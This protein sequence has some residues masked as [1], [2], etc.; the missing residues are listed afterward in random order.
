MCRSWENKRV[1]GTRDN[2]MFLSVSLSTIQVKH[3]SE[4]DFSFS[5][6]VLNTAPQKSASKNL[7]QEPQLEKDYAPGQY[8]A[9]DSHWWLGNIIHVIR[10]SSEFS[11]AKVQFLHPH[12]P[13]TSFHWHQKNDTCWVPLEHIWC[14]IPAPTTT[15]LGRNYRTTDN[16]LPTG[17]SQIFCICTVILS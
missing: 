11:D 5:V 6:N 7:S 13:A 17:Y 14:V 8:V 1:P 9:N 4:D 12:G 3:V 2:H 10:L 15:G 16:I